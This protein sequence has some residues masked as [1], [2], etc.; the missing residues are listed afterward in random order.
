MIN[1]F[2]ERDVTVHVRLGRL[3]ISWPEGGG[4]TMTGPAAEVFTGEWPEQR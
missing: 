2:T 1:G 4:I 3:Q